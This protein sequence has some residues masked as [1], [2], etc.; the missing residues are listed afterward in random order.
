MAYHGPVPSKSERIAENL[1]DIQRRME[2]AALR[3][4]RRGEAITL[5]AVTKTV[6]PA[7]AQLLYDLGIRHFAENRVEGARPKVEALPED[8]VWHCIGNLQRRKVREA[9]S[10]FA[11]LDGVDRISLVEELQKRLDQADAHKDVLLEI[12][13]SGES[14]KH[15]FSAQEIAEALDSVR[16]MNRLRVIGLMTMAPFDAPEEVL[17]SVFRGL[18]EAA[19]RHGLPVRSMGMTDDFEIAIEEGATEV[20]IGRALFA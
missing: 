9:V 4:G 11:R 7:E 2:A 6:G 18:R 12:N 15:G 5:V 16:Q 20:R 19:D 10:L 8:A 1:R 3:S 13:I 14:S 17:R